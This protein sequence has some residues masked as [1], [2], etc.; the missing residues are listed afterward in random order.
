MLASTSILVFG[1]VLGM[2]HALDPDHVV[3]VTT[4]VSRRRTVLS[5]G[6]IGAQWG[7]GHTLTILFVGGAIV[8]FRITVPP[9]LG[10]GLEMGVA[11]ML[12][13]L[14]VMN[15]SRAA[16][17]VA[18]SGARPMV[19]GF[20]HGLAGSAA[21][22]L[23]VLTATVAD[24]P[25]LALAYLLQFGLG[26]IAGMFL[27]TVAIALPSVLAVH[28]FAGAQRWLRVASGAAS[29]AFGLFLAH[30]IG[31]ED[32]LFTATPEWSPK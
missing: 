25:L 10:L 17:R 20:V 7:V 18:D 8:L 27:V 13:V 14:G 11:V 21:V 15:L 1:F 30:Q 29:I 23:L 24:A 16:N 6:A 31:F 2:R 12:V 26:T 4:I 19:V 28:R 9:R 5:A 3:A 22:A 32:G